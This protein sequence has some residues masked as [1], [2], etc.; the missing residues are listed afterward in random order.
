MQN[1]MINM[2][3]N[4]LK[5]KNPMMYQQINQLKQS[6]GNPM[7]LLKQVTGN[8]SK[9]QMNNFINQAKQMGFNEELLNQI[10]GINTQ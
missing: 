4:Q 1:Q 5:I 8:Y 6:N 2:L 3:M 10:S 9:E 7:E